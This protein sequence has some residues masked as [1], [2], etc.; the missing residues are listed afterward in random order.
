MERMLRMFGHLKCRAKAR[1]EHN[2]EEPNLEGLKFIE[3]DWSEQC[4]DAKE[5]IPDDAPEPVSLDREVVIAAFV[6]AD[7]A[8]DTETRRSVT[9]ILLFINWTPIKWCC[10]RQNAIETSSCGSEFVAARIATEM[11]IDFRHRLRMLGIKVDKPS[12]MLIDNYS[13]VLNTTLPSSSL[14]KKHNSIAFNEVRECVAARIPLGGHVRSECNISD[15]LTKSKGPAD[16]WNFL[17][18]L[19]H[20]RIGNFDSGAD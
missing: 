11:I 4:P 17:G 5:E 7:H 8:H 13:V 12:I 6:D 10:K 9:G 19:L 15:I 3:H 14:K 16:I 1:V 20:G 2:V 18:Y